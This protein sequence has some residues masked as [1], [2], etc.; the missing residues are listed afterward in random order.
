MLLKSYALKYLPS[1]QKSRQNHHRLKQPCCAVGRLSV[2]FM[3]HVYCRLLRKKYLPNLLYK[4]TMK[5]LE[6]GFSNVDHQVPNFCDARMLAW[7]A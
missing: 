1:R 4:P 5:G 2:V 7:S 3:I 6:V